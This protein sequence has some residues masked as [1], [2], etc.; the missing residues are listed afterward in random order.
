MEAIPNCISCEQY[1][2]GGTDG[3]RHME[4]L[5]NVFIVSSKRMERLKEPDVWSPPNC[6]SCEQ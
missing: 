2:D 6:F 5:L 1:A 4:A 3:A